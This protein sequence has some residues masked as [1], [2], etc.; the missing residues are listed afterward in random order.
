MKKPPTQK[1]IHTDSIKTAL[2]L[3][4]ELHAELQATADDNARSLNAEIVQRLQM[5]QHQAVM[6]ELAELKALLRKLIDMT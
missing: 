2:R 5:R 1:P 6:D 3:P 4:R